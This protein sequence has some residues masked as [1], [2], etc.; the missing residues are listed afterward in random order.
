MSTGSVLKEL[1]GEA[2]YSWADIAPFV[3]IGRETWRRHVLAGT[4]PQ[5]VR[6]SSRCTR[7]RG[8]DVLAWIESPATYRAG[9]VG[10][11]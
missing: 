11:K 10:Q 8:R 7:Y 3:R 6:L 2:L 9:T 5:P 1:A 4:A